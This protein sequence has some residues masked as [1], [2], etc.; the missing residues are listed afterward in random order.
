MKKLAIIIVATLLTTGL[1]AQQKDTLRLNVNG[2][3]LIILT[4]DINS[5]T[6]TDYNAIIKKLTEET[7]RIVA[8]QNKA[9]AE[10]SKQEGNGNLSPEEA[11]AAREK[12]A[13][14]TSV[15]LENLGE[16][17]ETWAAKY[18]EAMDENAS[19]PN[20]WTSE[21][22]QNAQKYES[23]NPPPPPAPEADNATTVIVDDDGVRI[24]N[25]T[26]WNSD[27]IKEARDKYKRNQTIGYFSWHFGW[28]N[29][30]N[31]NG[32]A[33][34]D[35]PVGF[36]PNQTTE[37]NFWPSMVWGLGF[38]GKT[39]FG[40]S[41]MY[42]KYGAE[43]NWHFFQLKGNT[44]VTKSNTVPNNPGFD[45][46]FFANDNTKSYSKSSF[47]MVYLDAPVMIEFDAS[48]PGKSNGF[49]IGVGG[50]GGLRLTSKNKLKYSDFNGDKAKVKD[51]NNFYTNGFRYGVLAQI[52]IGTF[53][54]TGK[55]DLN[56]L[57]KDSKNT[58][59]YQ[60]ASLTLGWV[61][62]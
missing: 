62:P 13:E 33:M 51:V 14:E 31:A 6:Q 52:G 40:E 58:P 46:I 32:L 56:T 29:W 4:N 17:I 37:L 7:K 19:A 12:V 9:M 25:N 18:G 11:S 24:E 49:S 38:G 15:K 35:G 45:G 16:E 55:Y 60:I 8:D 42:V 28:N 47:R 20:E 5:L 2:S 21:W 57:F 1:W 23:M 22:E 41:K 30:V 34:N 54:I 26:D 27:D 44:I 39:R 53:K 43:F 59:D 48:K 10:I 3:E 36:A 50:Y 61:F